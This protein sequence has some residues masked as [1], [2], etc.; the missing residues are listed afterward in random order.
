MVAPMKK[1]STVLASKVDVFIGI[2]PDAMHVEGAVKR[3]VTTK[4]DQLATVLGPDRDAIGAGDVDR[5]AS[6]REIARHDEAG[7]NR[8]EFAGRCEDLDTVIFTIAHVEPI[9]GVG[10]DEM[11]QG[12]LSGSVARLA[13]RM[14]QFALG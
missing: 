10:G 13:P 4:V 1:P 3:F 14:L 12:E 9:L 6:E 7:P 11:H 8:K 5:L 2:Q